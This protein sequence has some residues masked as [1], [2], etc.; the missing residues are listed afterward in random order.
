MD[1]SV[2]LDWHSV[3]QAMINIVMIRFAIFMVA[4]IVLLAMSVRAASIVF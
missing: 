1:Y 3:V 4:S 2:G